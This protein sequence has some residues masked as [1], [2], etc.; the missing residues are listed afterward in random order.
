MKS[1]LEKINKTNIC[2]VGLMGSGKS[3]IGKIL[4]EKLK[5]QYFDSDN[6]IEKKTKKT[7]NQIFEDY[8]EPYFRKLEEEIVLS[9]IDKK[10]SIISLGGGSILS[11][12]VRDKLFKIS[13]TIYLHVD[14]KTLYER[15]KGSKKRPLLKNT[16][17]KEEILRL[18][19]KRN[20]YYNNAN[21]IVNNSEKSSETIKLIIDYL[22]NINE[23]YKD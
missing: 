10:N 8:G 1:N 3:V 14:T 17:I 13:F 19:K 20:K 16:D 12:L 5:F 7:I 11:K 4:S 2:L 18:L 23:K 21:L 15:L 9:L 22:N 6:L